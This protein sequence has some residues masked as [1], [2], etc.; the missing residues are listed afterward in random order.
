MIEVTSVYGIPKSAIV[1]ST[2]T[3]TNT[4]GPTAIS[5]NAGCRTVTQ[6]KI[7]S[8]PSATATVV[9]IDSVCLSRIASVTANEITASDVTVMV[10]SSPNHRASISS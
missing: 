6:K 10:S 4:V 8:A 9:L 1:P 7:P 3:R 2:E 5:A